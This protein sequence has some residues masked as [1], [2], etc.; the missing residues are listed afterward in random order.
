LGAESIAVFDIFH[1]VNEGSI[2]RRIQIQNALNFFS[3]YSISKIRKHAFITS[4]AVTI[5]ATAAY[6]TSQPFLRKSVLAWSYVPGKAVCMVGAE[7]T[8]MS[9]ESL[10]LVGL[11]GASK[12][13]AVAT[14]VEVL[15][16]KVKVL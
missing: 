4:V 10:P 5:L 7:A 16:T 12:E 3:F 8:V 14:F 13:V 2:L 1:S 6:L 11:N 15:D 9:V